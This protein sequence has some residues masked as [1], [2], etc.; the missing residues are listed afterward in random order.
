MAVFENTKHAFYIF[1]LHLIT[2]TMYNFNCQ[3]LGIAY[4]IILKNVVKKISHK[5]TKKRIR[6]MT[7]R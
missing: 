6:F 3:L 4:T 1:I 5:F 7:K 2:Y